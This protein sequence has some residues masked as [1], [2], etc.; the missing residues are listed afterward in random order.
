MVCNKSYLKKLEKRRRFFVKCCRMVFGGSI[1]IASSLYCFMYWFLYT[2][3]FLTWVLTISI[4]AA[5]ASALLLI[6]FANKSEFYD[7]FGSPGNNYP[8]Y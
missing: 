6:V 4:I 5:V 3:D 2:N 7:T 1:I 8:F